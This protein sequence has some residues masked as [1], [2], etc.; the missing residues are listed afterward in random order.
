MRRVVAGIA[1]V[2]LGCPPPAMYTVERPGLGCDRA[3]RVAYKSVGQL[4][5]TVTNL[6]PPTPGN[7]GTISAKRI[8]PDGQE[9]RVRVAITCDERGARL[10]PIE[11]ALIPT[12]DFSRSF[13]YSFKTLVQQPDEEVPRAARGLEVQV[14]A[15]S[16]Y[17]A[18]LDLGGA[19]TVGGAVPVRII[20][21]NNTDRA[22]A[23]DPSRLEL[24]PADGAAAA[25]LSGAALE[26][27][28]A[29]GPAGDRVRG[30]LLRGR[31]VAAKTTV[32]AYLVYPRGIYREARVALVD[33]ETGETEGF[34]TPVE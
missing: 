27:A 5:Y 7:A 6:V 11:E 17:D 21:R 28:L 20:V 32:T 18:T 26:A 19:A 22:V 3:T 34:V 16:S 9:E 25:P 4:G 15:L 13:G 8:L 2:L 14:H 31:P 10:Q 29:P 23:L 33:V 24:V 12:F 30:D 1:L